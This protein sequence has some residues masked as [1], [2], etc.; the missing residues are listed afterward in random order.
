[1]SDHK[2]YAWPFKASYL[3]LPILLSM[4]PKF[5][6]IIDPAKQGEVVGMEVEFEVNWGDF[7]L[8][9]FVP[10][11]VQLLWLSNKIYDVGIDALADKKFE[12]ELRFD[13]AAIWPQMR[14]LKIE[15]GGWQIKN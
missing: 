9:L 12:R 5:L 14:K 2:D 1:M 4:R 6:P 8:N 13:F 11:G 3:L 7:L 10:V 15:L